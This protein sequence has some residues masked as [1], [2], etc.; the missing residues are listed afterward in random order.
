[1][2][3]SSLAGALCGSVL[4]F[5]STTTNAV[6]IDRGGGLIYDSDQDLTWTQNAGLSGVVKLPEATAWAENLVFGGFDDWRLPITTQFDDPTCSG[7]AR[8]AQNFTFFYEVRLDCR[9]G[10]M[11]LLTEAADPWNNPLFENV[12]ITR[13]WTA[14]PY[15]DGIDP[16]VNYPNYDVPCTIEPDNGDRTGFYWQWGFTGYDGVFNGPAFKT[17]LAGT[18][19]RYAWAVREGDVLSAVPIPAAIYLFGSGLIGLFGIRYRR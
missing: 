11:E 3:N 10:E 2:N 8:V 13:Y 5:V 16:C 18:N 4:A 1:M 12:N 14:T 15:R 19:D 9:G 6:L 7:D 17:T